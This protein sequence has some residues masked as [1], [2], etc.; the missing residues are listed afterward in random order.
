MQHAPVAQR[1]AQRERLALLARGRLRRELALERLALVRREPGRLARQAREV[2]QH[3]EA[4]RDRR[5]PLD[6]E[7][8][9]PA[10][11][12]EHPVEL[13]RGTRQR[14][15]HHRR[16]HDP[17]QEDAHGARPVSLREPARDQV[18]HAWKEARLADSEQDARHHQG[19]AVPDEGGGGGDD[20]PADHDPPHPYPR[21]DPVQDEVARDLEDHVAG[22]EDPRRQAE[23]GGRDREVLGQLRLGERDV[24]AIGVRDHVHHDQDRQQAPEGERDR[25]PSRVVQ[26]YVLVR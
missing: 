4:D 17:E 12:P 11:Q 22:E 6:Q 15:A 3:P 8:P 5:Q 23:Q 2:A 26:G 20:P 1:V 7:Q 16:D 25:P 13:E 18:D 21:P 10:L 24:H 9:L 19:G 14:A